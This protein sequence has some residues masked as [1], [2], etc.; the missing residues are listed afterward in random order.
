MPVTVKRKET[1]ETGKEQDASLTTFVYKARWFV[2]AQTD[3]EAMEL[4]EMPAWDAGRCMSA[5]DIERVAFIATEP[6]DKA[7][8]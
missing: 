1:D 8:Q 3:G 7:R 4:P 5:L 6:T 2:L